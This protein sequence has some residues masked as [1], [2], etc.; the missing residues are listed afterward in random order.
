VIARDDA[1]FSFDFL[2]PVVEDKPKGCWSIQ[3]D[4]SKSNA[5]IRSLLWPGFVAY[6]RANSSTYGY[7]YI[8]NGIKNADLPFLL[9]G[10]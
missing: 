5:T 7:C 3:T 10:I 2:D 8:G 1:L 6:H 4:A 9:S